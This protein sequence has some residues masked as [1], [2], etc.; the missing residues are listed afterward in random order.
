MNSRFQDYLK[1]CD[2]DENP[3]EFIKE[4]I[5][6]VGK[7]LKSD[8]FQMNLKRYSALANKNR[9]MI[10]QLIQEGEYCNCSLA[11]ILGLSEG[12]ITHHIKKLDDA[13]LIIGRNKGHFIFYSTTEDFKKQFSPS[14]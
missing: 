4:K 3:G 2:I 7:I 13:G 11:K 14:I 1:I 6:Y 5:D 9:L 8:D 10:Y 12:S